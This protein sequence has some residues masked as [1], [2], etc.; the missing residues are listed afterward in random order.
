MQLQ[1]IISG[2]FGPQMRHEDFV[3]GIAQRP[4]AAT[5]ATGSGTSVFIWDTASGASQQTLQQD[6][7]VSGVS[8]SP[9]GSLMAVSS[10]SGVTFW[11]ARTPAY[12]KLVTLKGNF[13]QLSFSPD[14]TALA[15]CVRTLASSP[16]EFAAGTQ[17]SYGNAP[18]LVVGRL[19]E[20]LSGT[21][22][23]STVQQRLTGPLGMT[24]TSWRCTR[25]RR[26]SRGTS[27]EGSKR[28][29]TRRISE[30]RRRPSS[31]TRSRASPICVVPAPPSATS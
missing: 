23:A 22:F 18:L 7:I 19:V 12:T 27:G 29:D 3:S 25:R 26:R 2:T 13:R 31:A 8:Y 5:L 6:G 16:R 4:G 21:D 11:D 30:R 24:A 14:G 15:T 17:F 28:S 1:D 9:D 20:V 10:N